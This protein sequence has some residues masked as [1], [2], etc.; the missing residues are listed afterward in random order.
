MT[1]IN[2]S[3]FCFL[4]LFL[5]FPVKPGYCHY[6]PVAE[7]NHVIEMHISPEKLSFTYV[8][9]VPESESNVV[10]KI[11]ETFY[12]NAEIDQAALDGYAEWLHLQYKGG[13]TISIDGKP[14]D[15]MPTQKPVY[16][17]SFGLIFKYEY[18]F[19]PPYKGVHD[20]L[21]LDRNDPEVVQGTET[22]LFLGEKKAKVTKQEKSRRRLQAKIRFRN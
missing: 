13:L 22:I 19:N 2:K 18:Y 11:L 20:F 9:W 17:G 12:P 5:T 4:I 8:I 14:L 10:R 3:I 15:Y 7:I 21:F 1:T 6:F 16:F